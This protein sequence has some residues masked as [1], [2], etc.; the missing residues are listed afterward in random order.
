MP[1]TRVRTPSGEI[2][3][4]RHPEGATERQIFAFAKR[5]MGRTLAKAATAKPEEPKSFAEETI[6]NI[7][8]SASRY[9][10]GLAEAVMN[11][12]E[13]AKTIG[14][15]GAGALSLGLGDDFQ[16]RLGISDESEQLATRVGELMVERYGSLDAAK[17]TLKNDPV[18]VLGDLSTVLGVGGVG[19]AKTAG[20]A[21]KTARAA[22]ETTSKI[23]GKI[24]PLAAVAAPVG[25]VAR[26][27]GEVAKQVT[28][29]TTGA[30][31]EPI[32]QA[33]QAGKAGGE[34]AAA[35]R[36]GLKNANP[37]QIVDVAKRGVDQIRETRNAQ[38]RQEMARFRKTPSP[39]D[40]SLIFQV[41]AKARRQADFKGESG[42]GAVNLIGKKQDAALSSVERI[43][44]RWAKSDPVDYHTPSGVDA[45]KK[46]VGEIV[47]K[48]GQDAGFGSPAY[49]SVKQVYDGIGG[50]LRK[51]DPMYARIM[52]DYSEASKLLDEIQKT[53]SLGEKAMPD[54]AL[55][56]LQSLMRN[57]VNT[58]YGAR[59]N[60]A[61]TLE[62]QGGV[63]L[64][65]TLAGQSLSELA[66]RGLSRVTAPIGAGVGVA[67]GNIPGIA[68]SLAASS[69]RL[70]GETAFRA[71][72]VAGL[73]GRAIGAI[74]GSGLITSPILRNIYA[75][76]GLLGQG[77]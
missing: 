68:A 21:S 70:V 35:F 64:L 11:P 54:T 2:I 76:T 53:L 45:L 28:G 51:H 37:E 72:Q 71:G 50:A 58:A 46:Q 27:P 20:M 10:G 77:Q 36:E 3:T 7:P 69:P 4:V 55:R 32:S 52:K 24:E 33:F 12:I 8:E 19:I 73:P 43:I 57:N 66:P 6:G 40:T 49:R 17:E 44:Q 38:Y 22:G 62:E 65:P 61:K 13:T 56:K 39:I 25:A 31:A 42:R 41:M 16:Q 60:L 5:E 63:S 15:L 34:S 30:G 14:Q 23:G 48:V 26:I 18:G 29:V 9:F 74:P 67:T 1:E 47:Q 75:Q 59:L